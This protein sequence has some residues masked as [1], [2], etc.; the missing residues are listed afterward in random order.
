MP[1]WSRFSREK[2]SADD[3]TARAPDQ[4]DLLMITESVLRQTITGLTLGGSR[5]MLCF[6]IGSALA[7]RPD[8][9][10]AATV[11]T[12][13]FPRIRST[14]DHFEV[15]EGQLGEISEWC[16]DRELWVLG[17]VHSHP[18]DEPHSRADETW[19]A[20]HR[21]GFLSVVFPFFAHNS[22]VRH[23][24]WRIYEAIGNGQWAQVDPEERLQIIPDVW[25][26]RV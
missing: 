26:P 16:A 14:Y 13:A 4:L 21:R 12:V 22:S 11:V 9:R 25:L 23:P 7:Q 1:E 17:Q 2:A 10:C 19:P 5:E 18:T 3:P 8:N 6:W 24:N 15:V 20:S